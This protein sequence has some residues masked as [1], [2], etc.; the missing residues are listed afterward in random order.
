VAIHKLPDGQRNTALKEV[1][2]AGFTLPVQQKAGPCIDESLLE[3]L[4]LLRRLSKHNTAQLEELRQQNAW[5]KQALEDLPAYLSSIIQQVAAST[6]SAL[7]PTAVE[8]AESPRLNK[9]TLDQRA[10]KMKKANW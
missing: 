6:P 2:R 10:A 5:L 3:E 4:E 7:A 9:D 1:L 8:I